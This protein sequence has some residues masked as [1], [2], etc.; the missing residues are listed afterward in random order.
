MTE[1]IIF[2]KLVLLALKGD[3]GREMERYSQSLRSMSPQ[4][5]YY[6]PDLLHVRLVQDGPGPRRVY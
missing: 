4:I 2:P 1:T 3:G 5:P 6:T